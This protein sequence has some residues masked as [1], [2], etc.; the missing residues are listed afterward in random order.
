M[1]PKG[2]QFLSAKQEKRDVLNKQK[3]SCDFDVHWSKAKNGVRA[4]SLLQDAFYPGSFLLG[5]QHI[6]PQAAGDVMEIGVGRGRNLP[7]YKSHKVR[8]YIGVDHSPNVRQ[9]C[10]M[11]E[12]VDFPVEVVASLPEALSLPS[13]SMDCVVSTY[14]LCSVKHPQKVMSEIWR[15]LKPGGLLLFCEQGR[16]PSRHVA[17]MQDKLTPFWRR[18]AFGRSLNRNMFRLISG[19]GFKMDFFEMDRFPL[20]PLILGYHYAGVAVKA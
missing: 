10:E 13:E 15:V 9:I 2:D 5:R 20:K 1:K 17:F 4:K 6:L 16:H 7:L 19:A 3:S 18:I 14:T 12:R 11:A 8:S